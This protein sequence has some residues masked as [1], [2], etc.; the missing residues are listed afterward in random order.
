MPAPNGHAPVRAR[1][2]GPVKRALIVGVNRYAQPGGNLK[3]CVNDALMMGEIAASSYGFDRD[4]IRLLTDERATTRNIRERL[5]WLTDDVPP[6]S[7]LLFHFSGHGSQI[8]D[9]SGDELDDH[10]DELICPHDMDW[11]DPLTDDEIA[12]YV[13]KVDPSVNLTIVLDCCHSGSGTRDF[14]VEPSARPAP[15]GRY[16]APPPDIGFRF[17]ARVELE[18]DAAA[19]RTV[20]LRGKRLPIGRPTLREQAQRISQHAFVI[21]GCKDDQ[22][23]ADAWIDND[24][25]GALTYSLSHSLTAARFSRGYKDLVSDAAGWLKGRRFT[26]D[27]QLSTPDVDPLCDFLQPFATHGAEGLDPGPSG[28][29]PPR[30]TRPPRPKTPVGSR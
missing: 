9:R 25:H 28:K 19:E 26:Q 16:L 2:R 21:S 13:A 11:D 3:G 23:S 10:L 18:V 7:V 6:G 4:H 24:Y 20:N 5:A 15:K 22:T 8:R 17:A 27:P 12:R 14:F 30:G 29:G 1:A